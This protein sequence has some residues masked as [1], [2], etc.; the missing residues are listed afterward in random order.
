MNKNGSEYNNHSNR[1]DFYH[2]FKI[3]KGELSEP[4]E[5]SKDKVPDF[6]PNSYLETY[7]YP[8]IGGNFTLEVEVI[9]TS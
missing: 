8:T 1:E 3:L 7:K 4:K 2:S 9:I 5:E 6:Q